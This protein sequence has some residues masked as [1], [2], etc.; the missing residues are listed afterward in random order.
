MCRKTLY[1]YFPVKE[2]IADAYVRNISH[3]L[4]QETFASLE[5]QSGTRSRLLTAL[6]N[7]YGW[8]I[9]NPELAGVV[10]RYRM[11]VINASPHS[12]QEKTGTQSAIAA[13]ISQAQA[14]GESREDLPA[15]S[16]S[17]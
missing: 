10:I 11:R 5:Q 15:E 7:A 3:E 12:E 9:K 13:I 2:A 1:N 8:V 6:N 16:I 14:A 17:Q 4:A